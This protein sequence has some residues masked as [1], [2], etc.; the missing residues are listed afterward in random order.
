MR[1]REGAKWYAE[2]GVPFGV[3][4]GERPL[5]RA[6]VE[7]AKLLTRKRLALRT[8]GESKRQP[9]NEEFMGTSFGEEAELR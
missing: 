5:R 6:T 9:T 8:A 2:F 7:N 1:G 3:P 4:N